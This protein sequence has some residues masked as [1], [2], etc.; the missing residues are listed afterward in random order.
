MKADLFAGIS[1]LFLSIVV[2]LVS[3]SFPVFAVSKA[4]PAYYPRTIA[5][6]FALACLGLIYESLKKKEIGNPMTG[7]LWLRLAIIVGI[8]VVYYFGIRILGYFSSTFLAGIALAMYVF[9]KFT[10]KNLL[11]STANA[12]IICISIY[13]IFTILLKA[14]LPKGILF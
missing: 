7:Y 2:W 3:A 13:F 11:V 14:P 4:G 1:G 8:L 10:A 9:Q 12:A 5:L 6:F